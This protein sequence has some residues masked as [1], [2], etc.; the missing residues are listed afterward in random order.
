MIRKRPKT[1]YRYCLY[2]FEVK[3][4]RILVGNMVEVVGDVPITMWPMS[5][6]VLYR[7]RDDER[8]IDFHGFDNREAAK[9]EG[10]EALRSEIWKHESALKKLKAKIKEG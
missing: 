2:D 10:L 5:K 4:V 9:R 1:L 8:K 3:K 7:V 6:S